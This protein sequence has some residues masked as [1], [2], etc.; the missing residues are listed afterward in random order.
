[1]PEPLKR[2]YDIAVAEANHVNLSDLATCL[3]ASEKLT[4]AY[5]DLEAQMRGNADSEGG[6]DA[7]W[8]RDFAASTAGYRL[9]KERL[10]VAVKVFQER[11]HKNRY[12]R[13]NL[14]SARK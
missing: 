13:R 7:V 9:T 6:D 2:Q 11:Q 12:S 10:L 5:V 8:Q 1:M 14:I 3:A 4:M